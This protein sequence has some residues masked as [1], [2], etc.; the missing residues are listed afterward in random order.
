M[1]K[2]YKYFYGINC[3]LNHERLRMNKG[4]HYTAELKPEAV[5]Q[6]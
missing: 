2:T 1:S 4:T 5:N 3:N 6:V